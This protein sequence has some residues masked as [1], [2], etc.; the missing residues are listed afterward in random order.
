MLWSLFLTS[1]TFIH[2]SFEHW[3]PLF[4]I[5]L[6][7]FLVI[8]YARKQ[9]ETS[10]TYIGVCLA[11]IPL[12]GVVIRMIITAYLGEFT[13]QK[14]LPFHLCRLTAIMAPFVFFKRNRFWLGVFYFWILV[15]T[16]NA[17]I[18][19]D[20]KNGWPHYDHIIY[21]LTHGFL[22]VLPFYAIFVFGLRINFQDIKNTFWV[23]N[24]YLVFTLILN[25]LLGSNY[26]YTMRKPEVA[27]LLDL[28]GPWPYYILAGEVL[29]MG[30]FL[31][32]YLPFWLL[33]LKEKRH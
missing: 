16:M 31:I 10:Q 14:E 29:I 20:L 33:K 7:S 11:L 24:A 23:T 22:N 8:L 32:F 18:T 27:S 9:S 19:P 13:V 28:M 4:F 5:G 15:G 6:I 1:R 30:F 17:N 3:F 21:F 2:F 12:L 26:F 25:Y